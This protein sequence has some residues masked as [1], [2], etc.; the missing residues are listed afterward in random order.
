VSVSLGVSFRTLGCKVNRV[1]SESIAAEL[2]GR[3]AQV[4][5]EAEACVVIVSTCTVTSE[6]DA[7]DRKAIRHALA[8]AGS[9]TVVVTGCGAT[10]DPAAFA[11]LGERVVVEPDKTRVAGLVAD[12]LVLPATG[13][14]VRARAGVAFR[15]RAL[16][17]V[18][19]G[20]D[21]FCAYCIVP[22]ARGVPRAVPLEEIRADARELV[23]AG[24]REIVVTGINVGRYSD[25]AADLSHVI[26][27][28]AA[29]GVERLRL[30]SI[31]PLDLTPQFLRVLGRTSSF[32]PHL[33]V[34]LQSGSDAVLSAMGRRYTSAEYAERISAAR[35]VMPGLAVTTDVLAG[36]PGETDAQA[37][38]T[39]RFCETLGFAALH[40][41]RFSARP[42]TPAA[43]MPEPVAPRVAGAR[44]ACPERLRA[45]H[46]TR[47]LGSHAC[48]LIE[49][50]GADGTGRGTTED[51]LRVMVPGTASQLGQTVRVRLELD[52]AG[53]LW[54]R[55][56]PG[57]C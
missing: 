35:E 15:T 33:H 18:Q 24:A 13:A 7:K 48:V 45:E 39:L 8:A 4:V 20:C 19:D 11:A 9:P 41:F 5:D 6:A 34:P 16:L 44:A 53:A 42:G 3:G 51:Y 56:K 52:S 38:E 32:C 2:L 55:P 37:E 26:E 47:R 1:E 27:A 36:F 31:E 40:V 30:S 23:A 54:G 49:T 46:V 21:A 10:L 12:L 57:A 22:Y 29:S 28:V 43:I 17:K 50:A 25:G 14:T